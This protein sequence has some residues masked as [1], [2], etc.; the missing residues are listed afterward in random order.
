MSEI[1]KSWDYL[2]VTASNE[3]QAKSYEQ[4]QSDLINESEELMKIFG[5]IIR[6]KT[7]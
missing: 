6:N 5:A 7:S 1:L 2:I 3:A 4:K